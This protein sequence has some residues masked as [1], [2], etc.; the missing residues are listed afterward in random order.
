[1]KARA[2]APC[3]LFFDDINLLF[4]SYCGLSREDDRDCDRALSQILTEMDDIHSKDDWRQYT[5]GIFVVGATSRPD[6]LR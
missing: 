2:A 5:K 1:M 6:L 3:I 4:N